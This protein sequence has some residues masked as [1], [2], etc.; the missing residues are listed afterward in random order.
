MY[1][2]E[3][4]KKLREIVEFT[5]FLGVFNRC[6]CYSKENITYYTN[7]AW[8]EALDNNSIAKKVIPELSGSLSS[9]NLEIVDFHKKAIKCLTDG[10]TIGKIHDNYHFMYDIIIQNEEKFDVF[11]TIISKLE[12][13][14]LEMI[15]TA[16]I[17]AYAIYFED[18][19]K[20]EIDINKIILKI[21]CTL[22]E[23]NSNDLMNEPYITSIVEGTYV[24]ETKIADVSI[25]LTNTIYTVISTM[26]N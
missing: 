15:E 24:R 18:H 12:D 3:K 5:V 22:L 8:M 9:S 25:A 26:K 21:C 4:N 20:N 10:T 7:L 14:K 6:Q 19:N 23:L 13:S 2:D 16:V 11:F 17:S 1:S